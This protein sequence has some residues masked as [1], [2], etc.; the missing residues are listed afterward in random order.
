MDCRVKPGNVDA[1]ERVTEPFL[2]TS[3]TPVITPNSSRKTRREFEKEM[4]NAILSR[5]RLQPQAITRYRHSH[6][7]QLEQGLAL[8]WQLVTP[9]LAPNPFNDTGITGPMSSRI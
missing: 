7:V 2:P 8:L 4:Y 9:R 3:K 5:I 1:D 6:L